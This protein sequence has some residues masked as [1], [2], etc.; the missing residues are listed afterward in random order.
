MPKHTFP[1]PPATPTLPGQKRS[2]A[3]WPHAAKGPL[4]GGGHDQ[5]CSG[6]GRPPRVPGKGSGR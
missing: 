3:R 2:G 5:G 4:K 1:I 6:P